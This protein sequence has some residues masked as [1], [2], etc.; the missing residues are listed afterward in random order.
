MLLLIAFSAL[1]VALAQD[2]PVNGP[3]PPAPSPAP[4]LLERCDPLQEC[5]PYMSR[6]QYSLDFFCCETGSGWVAAHVLNPLGVSFFFGS[7]STALAVAFWFEAFEIGTLTL[8]TSFIIFE[9]SELELETWAGSVIGDAL[10][11][12]SLG[13][14]LGYMLRTA[15][16]VPGPFEAW[17]MMSGWLR[18][19]YVLLWILYSASFILLSFVGDEGQ[20]WGLFIAIG[21]QAVLLLVVFP[22]TTRSSLD[23]AVV[24]QTRTRKY[25][26]Q[27][28]NTPNYR[29]AERVIV[30]PVPES[31]RWSL[32]VTWFFINVALASQNTGLYNWAANEYYQTWTM[33]VLVIAVLG[34]IIGLRP[35]RKSVR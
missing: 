15:F 1:T 28:H 17:P 34:L 30:R 11:Q 26:F 24:W 32:F 7:F 20:N 2:A 5:L 14:L 16:R 6:F 33:I 27:H 10:I 8:F 29:V 19:K 18:F 23:Q 21:V 12:G 31:R 35:K 25:V 3:I 4:G 22:F 9:T 13:A